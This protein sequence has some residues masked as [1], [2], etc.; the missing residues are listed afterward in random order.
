MSKA[1]AISCAK[2][3]KAHAHM[4]KAFL[5][6]R[7]F[8]EEIYLFLDDPQRS[9]SLGKTLA[10]I[11]SSAEVIVAIVGERYADSEWCQ[12]EQNTLVERLGKQKRRKRR[13][14]VGLVSGADLPEAL[15]VALNSASVAVVNLPL[16]V[17]GWEGFCAIEW[18]ANQI[19]G[20]ME[21]ARKRA[22]THRR[23]RDESDQKPEEWLLK[24]HLT[25]VTVADCANHPLAQGAEAVKVQRCAEVAK[26]GVTGAALLLG[27]LEQ[28]HVAQALKQATIDLWALADPGIVLEPGSRLHDN[29]YAKLRMGTMKLLLTMATDGPGDIGNAADVRVVCSHLLKFRDYVIRH[30]GA[31][32]PPLFVDIFE[33][34]V[35]CA[36]RKEPPGDDW[37][38]K[39]AIPQLL[40]IRDLLAS[41]ARQNFLSAEAA[42]KSVAIPRGLS[43]FRDFV[44]DGQ[45]FVTRKDVHYRASGSAA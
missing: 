26:Q 12:G 30:S 45:P 2:Q 21:D 6:E 43:Q 38:V 8:E 13:A 7:L 32:A 35:R 31:K 23:F 17:A 11:F 33:V 5:M 14:V 37:L 36:L 15:K 25:G 27:L 29:H 16:D 34:L 41:I 44:E 39:Q 18:F 1:V 19:F 22:L 10:G 9:H 42:T 40:M 20:E 4:L 3:E 28:C 24:R